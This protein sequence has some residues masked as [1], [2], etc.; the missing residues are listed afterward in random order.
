M[1]QLDKLC[2]ACYSIKTNG[3][4]STFKCIHE[5]MKIPPED[6]V[7]LVTFDINEQLKLLRAIQK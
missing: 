5:G 4:C 6:I 7:E 2:G 3:I 1:Y